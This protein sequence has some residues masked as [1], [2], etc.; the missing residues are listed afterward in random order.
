[1]LDLPPHK[2]F[3]VSDYSTLMQPCV[4]AW[5]RGSEYL[6]VGFSSRGLSRLLSHDKIGKEYTIEPQDQFLYWQCESEEIAEEFELQ[7]PDDK[8]QTFAASFQTSRNHILLHTNDREEANSDGF[9]EPLRRATAV[10]ITGGR[11][12]R[13]VKYYLG[14]A[15]EREIK[16][17]LTRG[18]VVGGSSAGASIQ[19]SYLVRAKPGNDQWPNGD[20]RIVM[21]PEYEVG[22]GLLPNSAIDQHVISLKRENAL[23]QVLEKYPNILGIGIDEATAIVVRGDSFSVTGA[24]KVIIH[25]RKKTP[26]FIAAGDEFNLRTR[27]VSR[28]RIR[29]PNY[30]FQD[31]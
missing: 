1:M 23:Q 13:L 18:G 4:Y 17:L 21:A 14:T 7:L 29:P 12:W 2:I 24:S 27:T 11:Q 6:Y 10:W 9:V 15:V 3:T 16:A 19:A 31:F 20:N 30:P 5:L 8:L 25:D 28:A 22:F 26:Y